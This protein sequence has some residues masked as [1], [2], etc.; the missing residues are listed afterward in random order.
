[1]RVVSRAALA[2]A[3]GGC[4]LF[5]PA[6][7]ATVGSATHCTADEQ[8]AAPTPFC[9]TTSETCQQCQVDPDCP[10]DQPVCAA[11]SCQICRDDSEC[12]DACLPDGSC[13]DPA[14]IVHAAPSGG[15][16]AC[17]A[18]VPC[19][20][21]T[22]VSRLS[23]AT[24]IVE[25]APGVYPRATALVLGTSATLDG[26]GATL[27]STTATAVIDVEAGDVT[28]IGLAIDGNAMAGAIC[29]QG[30]KLALVRAQ[31]T[32]SAPAVS[33]ACALTIDRSTIA[34]NPGDAIDVTAGPV[35]ITNSFVTGNASGV[36]LVG[37]A[38]GTIADTTIANNAGAPPPAM[39]VGLSCDSAGVV[40]END[41]IYNNPISGA[42]TASYC[43]VDAA[44]VGLGASD[45]TLDPMFVSP[46]ASY[47][48]A[49]ASPVRG[50]G[51]PA[52]TIDIDFDGEPRPQPVGT[53]PD[54]GADEIP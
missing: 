5:V 36:S 13:A 14:R 44:F 40:V 41:I 47:H 50:L 17:S 31:V 46:P 12:S 28:L 38:T 4:E 6:Q 21:D 52:S 18:A 51:D 42:C 53:P 34:S 1:M 9:D 32:G 3:L 48:L 43:D 26:D 35:A 30:G 19:D 25:L 2:L 11:G 10:A 33:A 29:R 45:V 54:L 22:A 15:G 23:A 7:R 49:P 8:C 27:R 16:T 20:L 24:D 39:P 37:V